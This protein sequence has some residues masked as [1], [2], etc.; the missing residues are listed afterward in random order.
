MGRLGAPRCDRVDHCSRQRPRA[1]GKLDMKSQFSAS[2]RR[3]PHLATGMTDRRT[4]EQR[5][6]HYA[7]RERRIARDA[8]SLAIT[9]TS[10]STASFDL[11][12]HGL[13]DYYTR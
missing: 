4:T 7:L 5:I 12:L 13:F 6:T 1:D 8:R 9:G 11:D 10:T 3:R 2:Q